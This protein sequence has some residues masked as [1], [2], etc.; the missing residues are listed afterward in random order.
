MQNPNNQNS[1]EEEDD[2]PAAPEKTVR[3]RQVFSIAHD[4]IIAGRIVY[5]HVGIQDGRAMCGLWQISAVILDA[6]LNQVDQFNEFVRPED[7][8]NAVCPWPQFVQF[9]ERNIDG[10]RVGMLL[11]WGGEA[12]KLI[13]LLNVSKRGAQLDMPQGIKY[14]CDPQCVVSSY[15][16]CGL[17]EQRRSRT[18]P[19]GY[20][21]G[22]V[23]QVAFGEELDRAAHDSLLNI[24]A[25]VRICK[26]KRVSKC[27]DKTKSVKL[28]DEVWK[29]R[30]TCRKDQPK[31]AHSPPDI[32]DS[33]MDHHA[34][35]QNLQLNHRNQSS[36]LLVSLENNDFGEVGLFSDNIGVATKD[37]VTVCT[38][39][40]KMEYGSQHE[41]M[42][43]THQI[44]SLRPWIKRAIKSTAVV[45]GGRAATS[46]AYLES[47]LKIARTLTD[48]VIQAEELFNS[49]KLD[50]LSTCQDWA[51]YISVRLEKSP[52]SIQEM[53]SFEKKVMGTIEEELVEPAGGSGD[54]PINRELEPG[55]SVHDSDGIKDEL[56]MVMIPPVNKISNIYAKQQ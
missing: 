1:Y 38:Q 10:N 50:F 40:N 47:A 23:Y 16:T 54:F 30:G 12:S 35:T 49:T 18:Q 2:K 3:K 8:V 4:D 33:T 44:V 42:S 51:T 11:A 26:D 7:P 39:N 21:I 14:F 41:S 27:I 43:T 20:E 22:T 36:P 48:E 46:Q 52:D 32:S 34:L 53:E 13:H 31:R 6:E 56:L 9:V 37:Q 5:V 29:R 28:I 25:Q 15:K 55:K 24:L 17:Q 45:D 19:T